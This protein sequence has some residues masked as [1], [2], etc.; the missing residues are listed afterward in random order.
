MPYKYNWVYPVSIV[1]MNRFIHACETGCYVTVSNR[2][3]PLSRDQN[4]KVLCE[5]REKN[6][7]GK[8]SLNIRTP[9]DGYLRIIFLIRSNNN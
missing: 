7:K 4:T 1:G 8:F 3:F 9:S 5:K 2:P 6:C